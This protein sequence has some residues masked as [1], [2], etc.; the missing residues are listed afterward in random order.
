[1]S[2]LLDSA[3]AAVEL[4]G[5][6]GADASSVAVS[7]SRGVDLEWRDGALERV[8]EKTRRS[9]SAEI[10]VNG[11]FSASSTSDLRPDALK[12]FFED[13]VAMTRLLEP[14][15]HRGLPDSDGY[16][17]RADVDLELYDES[18][19]HVD[20]LGR[21]D[22]VQ[23]LESLVRDSG[24]NLPIVSVSSSIS[25]GIGESARVH[26]NGFIGQR[27]VSSFSASA[28]LT[29]LDD[30]GRRPMGW[31]YT[32][33]RHQDDM[34]TLDW[35]ADQAC[36]RA[37]AQLGSGRVQTGKYTV[38]VDSRAIGRL[39]GALLSPIS[40]ALIQ[41]RR[42]LWEGRLGT[43]ITSPL[44]TIFDEPHRPRSLGAALWDSDGFA[45]QRRPIVERGVLST[46]LIDQ[47]YARKMGVEPT[48]GDTHDLDFALGTR[49]LNGLVIDVQDGL[50]IERFLGGNSNETT[51]EISLGCAGRF[52]RNGQLAEPFAE[53]N[54]AGHFGEI[55]NGLIALGNDPNPN[56]PM[57]CPSCVFE[58]I[59]LSGT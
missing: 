12:T 41:Q 56:S 23:Q 6:M 58:N 19:A 43:Q 4:A 10:Y 24:A 50:L 1:M 15:P 25:D 37:A 5:R 57:G 22:R 48:G 2:A 46:Y 26:S 49:D 20:S 27:K 40:G 11:R 36:K 14:D 7:R 52:I 32:Y 59:Q 38:V 29:V 34:D 51:G 9:L 42:S 3:L 44:I 55:W 28:M 18:A 47:Y 53:A 16:G 54:L 45:T 21:R 13:A 31:E 30:D 33:R 8:T 35:I 17:G 39:L